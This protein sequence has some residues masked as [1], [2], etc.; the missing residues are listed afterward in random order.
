MWLT[1]RKGQTMRFVS[2]S[3]K[4]RNTLLL[5]AINS[6]VYDSVEYSPNYDGTI[7]DLYI[8]ER[9]LIELPPVN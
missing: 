5:L 9:D 8:D 4:Y 2:L 6:V 3:F 7:N 1:M